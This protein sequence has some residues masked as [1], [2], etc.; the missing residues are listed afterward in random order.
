MYGWRKEC[1]EEAR[2]NGEDVD[3]EG[4]VEFA[5]PNKVIAYIRA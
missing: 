2:E 4:E 3:L 1:Y 5:D